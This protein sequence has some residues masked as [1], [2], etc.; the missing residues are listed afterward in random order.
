MTLSTIGKRVAIA[1]TMATLTTGLLAGG[2]SAAS[3]PAHGGTFECYYDASGNRVVK[4]HLP[5][6]ASFT[7]G[8]QVWWYAAVFKST[9]TG[10]RFV[11]YTRGSNLATGWA[12]RNGLVLGAF[13]PMAK[14]VDNRTFNGLIHGGTLTVAGP[15]TYM[16]GGYFWWKS[17]STSY[18]GTWATN[19][20]T[21][22]T[23]CRFGS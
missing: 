9:S 3:T 11:G 12:N 16:V 2:A 1:L 19:Y 17:F 6:I 22:L 18:T 15:G 8:E 20:G 4:A 21:S 14:L 7:T 23:T 10:P 5:Q 13:V